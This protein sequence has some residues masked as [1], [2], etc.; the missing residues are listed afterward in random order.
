MVPISAKCQRTALV[1]P[2]T[3]PLTVSEWLVMC[4]QDDYVVEVRHYRCP[5]WPNP[6]GPISNTFELINVVK[7][8]SNSKDGPVVVHDE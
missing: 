6:D 1:Q 5:R 2:Y 7:E 3:L 4:V 8:A